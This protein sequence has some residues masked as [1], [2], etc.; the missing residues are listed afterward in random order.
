MRTTIRRSIGMVRVVAHLTKGAAIMATVFPFIGRDR[1]RRIVKRWSDGVLDIFGLTLEIEGAPLGGEAQRPTLLVGNHIS[2]VDIYAYLS[3]AEIKFVA[4][5][6]VRSWPLIGWFAANLGTIFVE[7]DRPRDAVRV[8]EE[9]RG[10]LGEGHIVCVFPEGTTTDGSVVLPFSSVLISAAVDKAVPVQPVS[11]A[12]RRSDGEICRRA[13]FTGDATLLASIWELAGGDRSVVKLRFL[14]PIDGSG[15]DRR[16]LARRAEDAVRE[17]L[18][19]PPRV[20]A[21]DRSPASRSASPGDLTQARLAD[22]LGGIVAKAAARPE[23]AP[24]IAT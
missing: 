24:R 8:G 2:W 15:V 16:A 11:I 20:V 17:S 4:K 6:E 23:D 12:Y 9:V 7:R 19:Q 10:A 13:A 22:E 5:S 3:V 1:R 14:E 18:G 21:A